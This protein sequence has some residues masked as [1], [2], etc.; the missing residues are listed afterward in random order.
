MTRNDL[1]SYVKKEYGIEPDFPFDLDFESAVLRHKDTR[2]WFALVMYVRADRLGHDSDEMVDVVTMKCEP[3][4]IDMLIQQEGYHRA[5]HMNKT[6]WLTI[7]LESSV[8]DK[9]IKNLVD[10]SYRLTDKVKSKKRRGDNQ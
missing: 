5:Y 8:P 3:M 6:Q 9:A 7:E 4:M 2:K 1:F 10:L